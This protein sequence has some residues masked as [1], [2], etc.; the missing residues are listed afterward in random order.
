MGPSLSWDLIHWGGGGVI[1]F[2]QKGVCLTVSCWSSPYILKLI[3]EKTDLWCWDG[4]WLYTPSVRYWDSILIILIHIH[5]LDFQNCELYLKLVKNSVGAL[6][7]KKW[8]E[9]Q[10][11]SCIS[12]P[13]IDVHPISAFG[14]HRI[15]ESDKIVAFGTGMLPISMNPCNIGGINWLKFNASLVWFDGGY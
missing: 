15:L 4:S 6:G 11:A 9:K 2:Y 3:I 13:C 5:V 1:S 8:K 7:K 10:I 14:H 12:H